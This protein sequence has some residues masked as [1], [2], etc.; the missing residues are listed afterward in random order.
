MQNEHYLRTC[1]S[2]YVETRQKTVISQVT[3]IRANQGA[4]SVLSVAEESKK[5]VFTEIA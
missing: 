2:G 3:D 4:L 5:K 1:Q